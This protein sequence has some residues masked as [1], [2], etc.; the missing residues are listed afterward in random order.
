[1][2]C[3]IEEYTE[4]VLEL[5][6]QFEHVAESFDSKVRYEVRDKW[7]T[8]R[9]DLALSKD[10]E[11]GKRDVKNIIIPLLD[12]YKKR[13]MNEHKKGAHFPNEFDVS[14]ADLKN[15]FSNVKKRFDAI[16]NKL[17]SQGRSL[18]TI[19]CD[20]EELEEKMNYILNKMEFKKVVQGFTF[21]NT[22]TNSKIID[23]ASY[24]ENV[25]KWREDDL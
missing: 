24:C 6:K 23:F 2:G 17:K 12:S 8:M 4:L 22:L 1:M 15:Y 11:K 5:D 25:I 20:V 21:V 3:F 19:E 14:P 9:P 18:Y 16:A 13:W 7:Y 10:I